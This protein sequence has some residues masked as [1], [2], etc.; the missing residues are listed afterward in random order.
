MCQT[1]PASDDLRRCF[2]TFD[3]GSPDGDATVYWWRLPNGQLVVKPDYIPVEWMSRIAPEIDADGKVHL[4]WTDWN[5]GK[6]H[7][8]FSRAGKPTYCYRWIIEQVTGMILRHLDY[9]DHLCKRKA[10]L[11]Y[12]C[13]EVVSPLVNTQRGPGMGFWFKPK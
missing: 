11:T 13:F 6:G 9:V 7:A 4:L 2:V 8:K 10:C 5:N 12:E 3:L 1:N